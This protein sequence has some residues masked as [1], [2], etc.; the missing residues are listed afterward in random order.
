MVN[1]GNLA[2]VQ[3]GE[4]WTRKKCG[5]MDVI[6]DFTV[7][8]LK[9]RFT[10]HYIGLKGFRLLIYDQHL[11]DLKKPHLHQGC[12]HQPCME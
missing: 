5:A 10:F 8:C 2:I 11:D 1:D 3:S 6:G 12:F 7:T 4:E 9:V